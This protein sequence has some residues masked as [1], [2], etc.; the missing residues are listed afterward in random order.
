MNSL[1]AGRNDTA[2]LGDGKTGIFRFARRNQR[3]TDYGQHSEETRKLMSAAS[4]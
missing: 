3:G 4:A 2:A 1:L